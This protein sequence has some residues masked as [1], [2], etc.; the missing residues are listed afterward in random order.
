M[1]T[2]RVEAFSDCVFAFALTLLVLTIQAP[3]PRGDIG[4]QL[5]RLWP[6]YGAYALTVLV[7][8][9]IWVNH[10]AMFDQIKVVTWPLLFMN[11][12]MLGLVAFLPLPTRVLASALHVHNGERAATC[13]YG[14]A[15]TLCGAATVATWSYARRK[16]L[17]H[18]S[19]SETLAR[20]AERRFLIGP[21]LYLFAALT[22]LIAPLFSILLYAFLVIFFWYPGHALAPTLTEESSATQGGES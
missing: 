9:A 12:V 6:S 5:L 8:G 14:L 2:S 3:D 15:F 13:F 7:I 22:G 4:R 11:T 19:I 1:K 20:S 18:H 16:R 10:H 17:L 21:C